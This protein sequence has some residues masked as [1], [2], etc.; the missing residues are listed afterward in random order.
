MHQQPQLNPQGAATRGCSGG[1]QTVYKTPRH[2]GTRCA[3]V[4]PGGTPLYTRP[5]RLRQLHPNQP[6]FG[7][8]RCAVSAHFTF[9]RHGR[10][11]RRRRR[12][13]VQHGPFSFN[14][15]HGVVN[16]FTIDFTDTFTTSPLGWG[17]YVSKF[18]MIRNNSPTLVLGCGRGRDDTYHPHPSGLGVGTYH[19]LILSPPSH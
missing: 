7:A 16:N 12:W 14:T 8:N 5:V 19:F 13:R 11:Y 2:T 3:R 1:D 10:L 15:R 17:I 18:S 9:T 6:R 4:C